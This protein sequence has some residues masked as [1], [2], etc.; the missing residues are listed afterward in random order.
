MLANIGC[1]VGI[2]L[3]FNACE[4]ES[5]IDPDSMLHR[6]ALKFGD[7]DEMARPQL[8]TPCEWAR[9]F[10]DENNC[11]RTP[12][13]V[14]LPQFML[15]GT[16]ESVKAYLTLALLEIIPPGPSGVREMD[17]TVA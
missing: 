7:R 12:C 2:D 8:R 9:A 14:E 5:W 15:T 4:A 11:Y 17:W 6:L 3:G 10:T 16:V 1:M 13:V